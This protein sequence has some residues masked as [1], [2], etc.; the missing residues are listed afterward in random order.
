MSF[1]F[2]FYTKNVSK[3]LVLILQLGKCG[4]VEGG[5]EEIKKI[6]FLKMDKKSSTESPTAWFFRMY[7]MKL[8]IFIFFA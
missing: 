6:L 2:H 7:F 5:K 1:L 8:L 4:N 3:D